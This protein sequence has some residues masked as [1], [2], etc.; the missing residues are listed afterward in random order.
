MGKEKDFHAAVDLIYESV[1]DERLWTKALM[2]LADVCGTVA[3]LPWLGLQLPVAM[4]TVTNPA[5]EK[6]PRQIIHCL[7]DADRAP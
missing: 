4:V 6:W 5:M 7:A 2:L 3:E 1:L